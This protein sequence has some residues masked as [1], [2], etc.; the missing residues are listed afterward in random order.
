VFPIPWTFGPLLR[1]DTAQVWGF[2]GQSQCLGIPANDK[3]RIKM[4]RKNVLIVDPERDEGELCARALEARRNCKC[5]LTGKEKEAT[6]LLKDIPFDLLLLDVATATA[7]DFSLLKRVRRDYPNLVIILAAYIHQRELVQRAL[8][9][10]ARGHIVKP[11]KVDDFRRKIDG[12][13]EF[14]DSET[15]KVV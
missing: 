4:K 7:G 2:R 15:D 11:I 10:G 8:E 14:A 5:Y 9:Y 13:Y 12:F 3:A 1:R 6:T